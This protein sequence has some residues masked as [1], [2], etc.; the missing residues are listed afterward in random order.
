MAKIS[1]NVLNMDGK[2]V[3]TLDLDPT[4]FDAPPLEHLV[5]LMVRWQRAKGRA[6]THSTLTKGTMEGGA[7]KPWKQKGTGRARAGSSTSPLWVGGA[8]AHGP[9]PRSYEFRMNKQERRAALTAIL[10]ARHR[11]GRFIVL[12]S[13]AIKSAKTK[14]M[15][16]V[17]KKIGATG[18]TCLVIPELDAAIARS[19]RNLKG[20]MALSTLGAN[21]YDLVNANF[22]VSTKA[23]V[24][25]LT[26]R[27]RKE[28]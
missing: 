21:V 11:D 19:S 1:V 9:H 24:E 3:G 22:V 28:Q 20:V 7:K 6:G 23:G 25:A 15:A 17:L 12:D 4:V 16:K 5:H 18:K 14:D 2:E 26:S 10:S 8:V 13:L 27:C